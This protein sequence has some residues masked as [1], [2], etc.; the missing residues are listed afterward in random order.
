MV[1]KRYTAVIV[2]AGP[3]GIA[4]AVQLKRYGVDF[5]IFEKSSIGGLINEANFVENYPGLPNG[6][7]GS[8][9][10]ALLRKHLDNFGIAP[11]FAEVR[12][13]Y[14]DGGFKI[15]TEN[16]ETTGEFCILASGT[17]PKP[18]KLPL[19]GDIPISRSVLD[20]KKE[21]NRRIVIIGGGDAAID[22]ALNLA[23]DNDITVIS[24]SSLTAI[25]AILQRAY[26]HPRIEIIYGFKI[27][28]IF[29]DGDTVN[30]KIMKDGKPI[31]VEA[32]AVLAATGRDPELSLLLDKNLINN[33]KLY[34]AGDVKNGIYRQASIAVSDGI[35]AAMEIH[36]RLMRK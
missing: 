12:K 34:L 30:I 14:Y 28:S 19:E 3:A 4:A 24:R 20:L 13:I 32:D 25:P 2:G 1:N 31:A 7:P 22:Y 8:K 35:R 18:L 36:K 29:K 23:S 11:A 16:G 6:I 9:F 21:K 17:I 5:A 10:A 27:R 33:D 15:L 26:E